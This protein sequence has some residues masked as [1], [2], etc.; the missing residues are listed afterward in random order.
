MSTGIEDSL[1]WSHL[2]KKHGGN[3]RQR[4]RKIARALN[5]EEKKNRQNAS[6]AVSESIE[7]FEFDNG[8]STPRSKKRKADLLEIE[9]IVKN[10]EERHIPVDL[11]KHLKEIYDSLSSNRDSDRESPRDEFYRRPISALAKYDYGVISAQPA[12]LYSQV[13]MKGKVKDM[14]RNSV[15]AHENRCKSWHRMYTTAP[16]PGFSH[17]EGSWNRQE[18]FI[19]PAE[20]WDSFRTPDVVRYY[21][22]STNLHHKH[23]INPVCWGKYKNLTGQSI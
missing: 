4:R 8:L 20:N 18:P 11:P 13:V 3:F 14:D 17:M 21:S 22:G 2:A 10:A 6:R 19:C 15:K 1:I 23:M 12:S 9:K 5:Y 16:N 7:K